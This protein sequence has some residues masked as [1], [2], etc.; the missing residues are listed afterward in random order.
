MGQ[1]LLYWHKT[2]GVIIALLVL[3]F[4]VTGVLLNHTEELDLDNIYLESEPLLALY[5]IEVETDPVAFGIGGDWIS[6][7]GEIVFFNQTAMP[8]EDGQL[9][10]AVRQNDQI[11]IAIT[12]ELHLVTLQGDLIESLSGYEGVPAGMSQIG[13]TDTNDLIIRSAHG[14]YLADLDAL[15]WKVY[16]GP[17]ALWSQS[18]ALP[19]ELE[20]ALLRA[21]RGK[22]LSVERLLLDL[23][24]GRVFGKFGVYLMDVTAILLMLLAISGVWMWFV[25]N[26]R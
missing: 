10:G 11:V 25:V 9:I 1:K 16:D 12:E 21:Y 13:V 15:E 8:F 4:C 17:P 23:H 5:N 3:L 20:S 22:G 18:V 7:L 19:T 24:S 2:I 6:Q 26:K 14:D